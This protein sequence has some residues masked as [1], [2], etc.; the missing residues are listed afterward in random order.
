MCDTSHQILHLIRILSTLSLS[1]LVASISL[2]VISP[3]SRLVSPEVM[4]KD[5]AITW[6]VLRS[7]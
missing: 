3:A 4:L 5:G 1:N 6:F 7:M 2:L